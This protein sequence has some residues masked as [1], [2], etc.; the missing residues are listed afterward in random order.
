MKL[1]QSRIVGVQS[2]SGAVEIEL[3][4]ASFEDTSRPIKMIVKPDKFW[5]EKGMYGITCQ[6]QDLPN[7]LVVATNREYVGDGKATI[8]IKEM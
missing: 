4:L 2:N 1:T 6:L 3:Q 7:H 5:P 8:Y